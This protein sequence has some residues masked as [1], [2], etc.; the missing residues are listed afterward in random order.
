MNRMKLNLSKTWEL[1]MRGETQSLHMIERESEFKL[2]GVTL[3]ENPRNWDSHFH[4]TMNKANSVLYIL[5]ICKYL[6]L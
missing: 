5:R 6:I 1:V 2:L 4:D 3:P